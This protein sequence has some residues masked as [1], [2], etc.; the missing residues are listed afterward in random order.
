MSDHLFKR[1][2]KI[3]EPAIKITGSDPDADITAFPAR[4]SIQRAS[5]T[6]SKP[7]VNNKPP[8]PVFTRRSELSSRPASGASASSSLLPPP[9]TLNPPKSLMQY[10][11]PA[12]SA[13]A[14]SSE[15]H[16]TPSAKPTARKKVALKPGYSAMDWAA[17]RNSGKNLRGVDYPG[18]IRVTEE[19]LKAH[20]TRDDCWTVLGGRVYNLTPYMPFHPGGEKI[21]MAIAGKDGTGLFMRTHSWVNFE[22]M[23]DRCL[24]GVYVP[25]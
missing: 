5:S 24:V 18:I 13:R 17:L 9:S 11:S 4:D 7:F 14:P 12:A 20:K 10:T 3:S 1:P 22:N 23:L 25:N 16:L 19:E 15:S 6:Q 8:P 2:I 21:L